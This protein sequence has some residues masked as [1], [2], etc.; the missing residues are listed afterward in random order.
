MFGFIRPVK[1]ELRVK[2]LE[3]FQGIYCGLCHT[4]RK[5]YGFIHTLSLSYDCAFLA[6]VLDSLTE[7]DMTCRRRCVASCI[8]A[9]AAAEGTEGLSVAADVSVI[10][11]YQKLEDTQQ[12]ERGVKKQAARFLKLFLRRGYQKAV[13]KQP[14]FAAAAKECLVSLRR[15]EEDKTPS[16]DRPADTFARLLA[17]A[18]PE[19]EGSEKRILRELFY[20]TGRWVYLIDACQDIK[21]DF[22]SGSYNPVLLRFRLDKPDF[23]PVR[24]QL[25]RTL[26]NSLAAMYGAFILLDI[27]RDSGLIENILCLGLPTVT[28]QVLEGTY[29]NNGGRNRH[30][31]L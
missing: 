25:E 2:E 6:L 3:R 21:D 8:K 30:G 5:R 17:S 9:R 23:T 24:E 13:L 18:V 4:I 20:H 26:E 29:R 14:V 7:D 12:D 19:L 22:K 27:K 15:L 11:T 31:S 16:L 28:R 1:P 10:L